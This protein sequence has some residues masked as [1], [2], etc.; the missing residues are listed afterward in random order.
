MAMTSR[1]RQRTTEA[2]MTHALDLF[3]RQGYEQTSVAEIAAAAGVSEMTFFR[4]FPTKDRVLLDDPYDAT[5]VAAVATRSPAEL[6]LLRTVN[7]LLTA[8][9]AIPEPGVA[10]VRRRTRVVARTP[11]LRS[12]AW[13]NNQRTEDAVTGQLVADGSDPLESRAAV[14]AVLAALTTA[15]LWWAGEDDADLSAAMTRALSVFDR[16]LD[17][18]Q[19][20]AG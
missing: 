19:I 11:S 16:E 2:L 6:P 5:L 12:A 7:A 3:E 18:G 10:L 14:A 1:R 4:H 13:Q 17:R 15:L 8:W 20:H 9:R